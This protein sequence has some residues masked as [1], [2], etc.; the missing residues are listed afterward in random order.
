ME[1]DN[2]IHT[3][4][5]ESKELESKRK[6]Q[7]RLGGKGE[8]ERNIKKN[9][10][11]YNR[12]CSSVPSNN[13]G[14]REKLVPPLFSPGLEQSEAV[15]CRELNPAR[16]ATG[17]VSLC[18]SLDNSQLQDWSLSSLAWKTR[19]YS[20]DTGFRSVQQPHNVAA[21]RVLGSNRK[22][23]VKL[24]SDVSDIYRCSRQ[25]AHRVVRHVES[26]GLYWNSV[27]NR[28]LY[29]ENQFNTGLE[30]NKSS[31]NISAA[32]R[33]IWTNIFETFPI[34]LVYS[35]MS[36]TQV[37]RLIGAN[38]QQGKG[39]FQ[40]PPEVSAVW[41]GNMAGRHLA[42]T[43]TREKRRG[44]TEVGVGDTQTEEKSWQ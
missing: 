9:I 15:K 17:V 12:R 29:D 18:N 16:V 4:F 32:L 38:L 43:G 5:S 44:E 22:T 40:L 10:L 24:D 2:I 34:I 28:W 3:S 35:Y 23:D 11:R 21:P 36:G 8:K 6:R 13:G 25:S 33:K 41:R 26:V 39:H 1:G 30:G 37:D 20:H 31:I 14:T 27:W 19:D 7:R 42:C